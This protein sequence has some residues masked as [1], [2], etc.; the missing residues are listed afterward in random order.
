[1][2]SEAKKRYSKCVISQETQKILTVDL[3]RAD[4]LKNIKEGECGISNAEAGKAS[5]KTL[6]LVKNILFPSLLAHTGKT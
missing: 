1:M 5:G 3:Q 6:C 2:V 4:Y